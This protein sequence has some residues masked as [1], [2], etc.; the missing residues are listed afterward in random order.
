MFRARQTL[1][2][3]KLTLQSKQ[4]CSSTTKPNNNN[5]KS[6][7]EKT[8]SKVSKYEEASRQLDNLDFMKAAKILFS[9][10]PKKKKFGH[11]V[12]H[13]LSI[14]SSYGVLILRL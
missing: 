11:F 9:D 6:I 8:D 10:P 4:F 14:G 3:I 13:V 5:N 1:A 2:R 12:E 7:S